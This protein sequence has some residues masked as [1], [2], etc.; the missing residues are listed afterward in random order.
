MES[1]NPSVL[2]YEVIQWILN[3]LLS[4]APP[5]PHPLLRRPR[6][7]VVG[8]GL[9]GVASAA[10]CVGHGFDVMIFE[11][12]PRERLGGIWSVRLVSGRSLHS[13]L[14]FLQRVNNTSGLQIHSIMYRFHPSVQWESGYPTRQQII[15]QITNL[16]KR[17]HLDEKTEFQTKVEK[18]YKDSTGRWVVN[19]AANGHFDGVIAAVGSCGDPQMPRLPSQEK[20]EGIIV[21]SSELTADQID[22]K[23]KRILVV[24]GGASAV[25]AVEFAVKTGAA[26]T[27]ILSR[28]DKWIIP[29]NAVVDIILAFNIFG[30]ETIFSWIPETLLR[31]FFYR[32]L[33]DLAPTSSKG[34]FTDTPMVN[35]EIFHQIRTGK[36]SW[37]RGD[38]LRV[39]ENGIYFNHRDQ[40]VPKG[41]P[42][43]EMHVKGDIII[44]AT[45]FARPSLRFL[46]DECFQ[47][48]YS[49]PNYYL[50]VFPTQD[51]S[52]V[53]TNSTYLNALGAC[54]LFSVYQNFR[55]NVYFASFASHHASTNR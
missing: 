8:A 54:P 28:S 31:R 10:H 46:P 45:G 48:P 36:A 43:H 34:L 33:T 40:G 2:V 29:R 49:P 3:I 24:G 14:T 47:P 52:I 21:H 20:F 22:A 50:Q 5:P 9:T 53:C 35:S 42:G 4:P 17:Y 13:V 38:I 23:G 25:E 19:N 15:D 26:S 16:W 6:I 37:L 27:T 7:A 51:P 44:M 30:Q 41:G 18:I 1:F 55:L 39:E 11:E 12:G 32:D